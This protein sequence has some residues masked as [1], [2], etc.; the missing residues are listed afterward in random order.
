M[1]EAEQPRV[2]DNALASV[3]DSRAEVARLKLETLENVA[4]I[5]VRYQDWRQWLR[6]SRESLYALESKLT[7]LD[8]DI[9]WQRDVSDAIRKKKETEA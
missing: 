1:T 8:A 5:G 9:K 6:R 2:L 3:E 7:D 4:L